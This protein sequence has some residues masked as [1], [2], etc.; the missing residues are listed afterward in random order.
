MLIEPGVCELRLPSTW[1]DVRVMAPIER[2]GACKGEKAITII[3]RLSRV[4]GAGRTAS[5]PRVAGMI[6]WR[7]TRVTTHT[8][9]T[10]R[11]HGEL[12]SLSEIQMSTREKRI[13]LYTGGCAAARCCCCGTQKMLRPCGPTSLRTRS[14]SLVNERPYT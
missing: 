12:E 14:P 11:Q 13:I 1:A 7:L 3:A 10:G 9:A 2:V 5:V 8:H 6:V 4:P